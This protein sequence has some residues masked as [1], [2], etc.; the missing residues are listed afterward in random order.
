ML[1]LGLLVQGPFPA[2]AAHLALPRSVLCSQEHHGDD[3]H[4]LA[5]DR[6]GHRAHHPARRLVLPRGYVT[7]SGCGSGLLWKMGV[8]L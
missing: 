5:T 6:R 3:D 1:A 4:S 8:S 2:L 7:A